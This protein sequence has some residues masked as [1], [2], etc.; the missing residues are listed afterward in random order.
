M[1]YC[2]IESESDSIRTV[3]YFIETYSLRKK[4]INYLLK[5]AEL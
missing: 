2:A 4:R 5:S 3:R 1:K